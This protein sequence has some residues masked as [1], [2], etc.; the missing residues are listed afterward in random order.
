M[1]TKA[2]RGKD[3]VQVIVESESGS[4]DGRSS[5][6]DSDSDSG[7]ALSEEESTST[8]PTQTSSITDS[9]SR[10][11]RRDKRG[12][13]HNR[14]HSRSKARG[15][16]RGKS[17]DNKY[18]AKGRRA[19]RSRSRRREASR[20]RH[21]TSLSRKP[22]RFC[23]P[24]SSPRHTF[25]TRLPSPPP[26]PPPPPP[27]VAPIYM[28]QQSPTIRAEKFEKMKDEA[29]LAGRADEKKKNRALD[30]MSSNSRS[31]RPSSRT[32][33]GVRHF[34]PNIERPE[35]RREK[36]REMTSITIVLTEEEAPNI[37]TLAPTVHVPLSFPHLGPALIEPAT[38]TIPA[39]GPMGIGTMIHTKTPTMKALTV[40][41]WTSMTH[42]MGIMGTERAIT[43]RI[44]MRC[45]GKGTPSSR[46]LS[47][48]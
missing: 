6:D 5:L 9:S 23:D 37:T 1:A 2:G 14:G 17:R 35:L 16:I 13:S 18:K 19:S 41:S 34:V 42:R 7:L 20:S 29:Y 48:A 31:P 38:P 8:G 32:R 22:E 44:A 28:Q 11:G 4:S 43:R 39:A 36:R 45:C 27:P 40:S 25:E 26:P 3:K 12:R 30:E 47:R 24:F 21:P 15:N 10:F 46:G 33:A